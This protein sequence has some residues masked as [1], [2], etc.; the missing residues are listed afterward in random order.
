MKNAIMLLL[1]NLTITTFLYSQNGLPDN[2][3]RKDLSLLV[4]KYSQARENRDTTLL[5]NILSGDIDQLVST[6]EWRNGTESA[7]KGMLNSS[8]STPGTR[9]LAIEKIKMLSPVI[10]IIDCRY[11]IQ[12]ASGNPKKMWSTFI[13]VS[14]K[15]VWK[16]S[17]IRNMLPVAS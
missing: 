2:R 10:A 13:V 3:Q 4:D 16:I 8:A 11:E 17:A 7:V 1:F 15:G 14:L 9:T 5:K 12:N 6:G